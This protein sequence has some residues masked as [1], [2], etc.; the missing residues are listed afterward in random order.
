MY[1]LTQLRMRFH[2][3]GFDSIQ[4]ESSKWDLVPRF[5]SVLFCSFWRS[6]NTAAVL[7]VAAAS[8]ERRE[9]VLGADHQERERA[10]MPPPPVV[11]PGCQ[12]H[13]QHARPHARAQAGRK[14]QSSWKTRVWSEPTRCS[15]QAEQL[16]PAS[17]SA[18]LPFTHQHTADLRGKDATIRGLLV[19]PGL[20]WRTDPM[21][22]GVGGLWLWLEKQQ[23]ACYLVLSYCWCLI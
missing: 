2:Q 20:S 3:T 16:W 6:V 9:I 13:A 1:T 17:A 23:A 19:H 12:A 10:R 15:C 22:R 14:R 8:S 4:H 5:I 7:F 11:C 21:W 18:S